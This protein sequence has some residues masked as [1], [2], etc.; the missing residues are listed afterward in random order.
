M[1]K[2][3]KEVV[4]LRGKK[5]HLR[6][7]TKGDIPLFLRWFNDEEV[8]RYIKIFL[9]LTEAGEIEWIDNMH[10]NQDKNIVLGIVEAKTGKLIGTMGLH[11]IN[12]KDRRAMTGAVIGEKRFWGRGYGSEAKMLFLNYAFNTL[13]L[14]KI[15]SAVLSFNERSQ[16]YNKKC[17]YKTEGVLRRHVYKD[18]KYRDEVL[19]AVFKEDWLPLWKKFKKA[20]RL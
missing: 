11:N 20:G 2:H 13:N 15:C 1:K 12:W 9:P 16:A 8:S 4:F 7:I 5:V 3:G 19:M 18:G 10:K 6:P 17:G 14:R